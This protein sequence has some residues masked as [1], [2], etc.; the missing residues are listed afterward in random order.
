MTVESFVSMKRAMQCYIIIT[1]MR[2]VK[3]HPVTWSS[4]SCPVEA[5]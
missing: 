5:F 4:V 2:Q 1:M 3:V